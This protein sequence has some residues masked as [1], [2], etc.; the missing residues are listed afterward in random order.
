MVQE[1]RQWMLEEPRVAEG[2]TGGEGGETLDAGGNHWL[3]KVR[4]MVKEVR[5]WMLEGAMGCRM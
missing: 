1:V 3:Q 5:H 4:Q 2:E